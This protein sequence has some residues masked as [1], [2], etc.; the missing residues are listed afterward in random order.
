MSRSE[1]IGIGDVTLVG[2]NLIFFAEKNFDR[3][4]NLNLSVI[5]N[6]KSI[7]VKL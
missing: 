5:F 4:R 3:D 2:L 6:S 1:I 7:F